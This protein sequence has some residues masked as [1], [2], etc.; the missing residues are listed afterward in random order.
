MDK[1]LHLLTY[2]LFIN[3]N[4]GFR[5]KTNPKKQNASRFFRIHLIYKWNRVL[6]IIMS[7]WMANWATRRTCI[8]PLLEPFCALSPSNFAFTEDGDWSTNLSR[9]WCFQVFADISARLSRKKQNNYTWYLVKHF[10]CVFVPHKP[11]CVSIVLPF[12]FV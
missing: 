1:V 10:T 7:R 4:S 11:W 6:V 8:D 9:S 12:F 2:F 3:I 5:G